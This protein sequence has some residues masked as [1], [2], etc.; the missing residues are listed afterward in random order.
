M[1]QSGVLPL[2]ADE[3]LGLLDAAGALGAPLVIPIKL[4]LAALRAR[5]DS[6]PTLFRGLVPVTRRSA[7]GVRADTDTLRRRLAALPEADW[8]GALLQLVR[9]QA[10]FVLGYTGPEAIE[11]D[12]AFRD[13]GFDSLAAVELRNGITAET[14]L[15]LPTTL[16]FDYPSSLALARYLLEEVSGTVAESLPATTSAV[17]D[18]EPIVIIGMSCRYPGGVS[19]PEELWRLVVEGRDAISEFP[20]NRGW[21]IEHIYDPTG[22][23]PDTSYTNKGG[24]LHQAGEFDPGFFGIS[25]NEALMM[26]PQQ[27]LLLEASWEV[28]ERAGIDPSTLRSSATGVFAGMMYHDYTYNSSTGAIA[29]GRISYVLG[30][31]GPSVTVD[32]ACSSSLVAL[33]LAVQALRSGE[34]SLA[35]AGGVAMMAT[36][37]VFIEF[38]R[39]R[40]L[41]PDGRSKSFAAGADGTVWGEGVGMLAVERLS[42]ARR[43]GHRVLAVVRGSA[44]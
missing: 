21:D 9:A 19:S 29:S 5:A 31:E 39:Q 33:H 26:D 1:A 2:S 6:L 3:G 28:L 12:R 32:T 25:P 16:V 42:D 17:V 37:E 44:V 13:L 20:V 18:D 43:N 22:T 4:D 8:E 11:P 35:L 41:S 38:S 27:R 24:F 15:R 34:C 30:L 36:P 40:G 23:R 10:A 7:V 14:G